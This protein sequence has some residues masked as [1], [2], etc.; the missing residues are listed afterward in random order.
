MTTVDAGR[1]VDDA[2]EKEATKMNSDSSM[3]R[4]LFFDGGIEHWK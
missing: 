1:E 3:N 4:I 2:V